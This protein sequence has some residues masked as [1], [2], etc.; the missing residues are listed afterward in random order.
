MLHKKQTSYSELGF[1]S[2]YQS[3]PKFRKKIRLVF[4]STFEPLFLI[5]LALPTGN[6]LQYI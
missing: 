1:N 5:P 3:W 4:V 6:V 2:S